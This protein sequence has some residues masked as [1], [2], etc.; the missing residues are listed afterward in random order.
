MVAMIVSL[1]VS[2]SL[3]ERS[4]G[5]RRRVYLFCGGSISPEAGLPDAI[6]IFK[7]RPP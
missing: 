6:P 3:K 2:L 4:T 7:R 5:L 1:N